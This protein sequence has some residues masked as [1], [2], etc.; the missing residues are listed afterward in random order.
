MPILFTLLAFEPC[1][2]AD[3]GESMTHFIF[4]PLGETIYRMIC[5]YM[6][7]KISKMSVCVCVCVFKGCIFMTNVTWKAVNVKTGTGISLLLSKI[8]NGTARLRITIRP[9]NRTNNTCAFAT[10]ALQRN[11]EFNPGIFGT[12]PSIEVL[13]DHP[14]WFQS[15]GNIKIATLLRIKP[16]TAVHGLWLCATVIYV[17]M[18]VNIVFIATEFL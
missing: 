5:I 3:R 6:N 15:Q 8:T 16:G 2:T 14:S 9:M 7:Y 1:F 13:L 18:K 11:L 10:F 12:E 4:L 17:K